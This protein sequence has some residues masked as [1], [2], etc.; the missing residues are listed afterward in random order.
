MR[1]SPKPSFRCAIYT[2][3]STDHGLEQ[4]FNSLDAQREAAE[5]YIKSQA[6]EGWQCLPAQYNDGGFSGGSIERP[7]LQQILSDIRSG[8]IDIVIV[9]KVDRL[10]RSLADFAKLVELF[11]QHDVSFVSVTQAFNTTSSMGRLTLNVLLSFAQF[12]REVTGERIRDKIAASKK[13]GLWMGG[14]V[15]L[16]Y[17]VYERT[18]VI[19][20]E[21]AELVRTLYRS[22]TACGSVH[23]LKKQL[24]TQGCRLPIRTD[25]AGKQSGGGLFGQGHLYKILSNPLYIGEIVHKG[26]RYPGQHEALIDPA[27]WEA[28]QLRLAEQAQAFKNRRR[29]SDALLLGRLFDDRGNAMSPSYAQK[30]SI[31]YRYYTS[32]ALLQGRKAEVGSRPRVPA[33]ELEQVVL[34]HLRNCPLPSGV[35]PLTNPDGKLELM[36]TRTL[37][38]ALLEKVVVSKGK[39]ALSFKSEE[40]NGQKPIVAEIDWSPKPGTRKREIIQAGSQSSRAMRSEAR[41]RLLIAL[42]KARQWLAEIIADPDVT[43]QTIADREGCSERSARM[44]LNLAFLSP[45]IVRAVIDGTLAR[46]AGMSGMTDLPIS[47]IDQMKV[48]LER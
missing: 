36:D 40:G 42:T 12:E 3:V 6:H 37:I 7:A 35:P 22:Y 28:V 17:R 16:G 24:D 33:A 13:K 34:D 46:G 1:A 9:Y 26:Q 45:E 11:D 27:L 44:T 25:G 30:G 39:V 41:S 31:R 43:M 14:V 48:I 23:E 32:Q 38:E 8:L 47:W 10:T 5:A 21:H 20:E 29:A 4:E 19:H 15:P 18:L 2:R